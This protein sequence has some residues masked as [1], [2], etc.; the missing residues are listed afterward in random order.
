MAQCPQ[1]PLGSQSRRGR[2]NSASDSGG[3]AW[4][5]FLAPELPGIPVWLSLIP[6]SWLLP[7]GAWL[8][9]LF[10]PSLPPPPD[11][12]MA[13]LALCQIP[14]TF[15]TSPFIVL[16]SREDCSELPHRPS[17]LS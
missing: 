12:R 15:K 17:P 13:L 14:D 6:W 2:R 16:L 5:H 3:G 10:S 4:T 11:P 8:R 7:L 1:I 9:L